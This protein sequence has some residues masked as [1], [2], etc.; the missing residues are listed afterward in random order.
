MTQDSLRFDLYSLTLSG[1]NC[2]GSITLKDL[3]D[4]KT[5][6]RLF[7]GS[8]FRFFFVGLSVILLV[9]THVHS[10][11]SSRLSTT[12]QLISVYA[13]YL[14]RYSSVTRGITHDTVTSLSSSSVRRPLTPPRFFTFYLFLLSLLRPLFRPEDLSFFCPV[15]DF[16]LFLYSC[17]T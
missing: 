6:T 4:L 1:R 3:F 8:F 7:F 17:L 15:T 5:P 12:L 14:S 16:P 9:V 13:R 10:S 2:F 11:P